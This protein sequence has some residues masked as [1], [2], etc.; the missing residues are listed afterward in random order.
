MNLLNASGAPKG[1]PSR[2]FIM[3]KLSLALS[4]QQQGSDICSSLVIGPFG[5]SDT[6]DGVLPEFPQGRSEQSIL[7]KYKYRQKLCKYSYFLGFLYN[8]LS[9]FIFVKL[10]HNLFLEALPSPSNHS[11]T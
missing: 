8:Y 5:E 10:F 2:R 7:G 9:P 11:R 4:T 3:L 1:S 6:Q